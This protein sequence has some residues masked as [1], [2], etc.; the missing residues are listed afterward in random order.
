MLLHSNQTQRSQGIQYSNARL[1]G[2]YCAHS[3]H[4]YACVATT[5]P[6]C[7]GGGVGFTDFVALLLVAT[8]LLEFILLFNRIYLW[9][10][11]SIFAAVVIVVACGTIV[12]CAVAVASTQVSPTYRHP[13]GVCLSCCMS[14]C[15]AVFFICVARMWQLP[16][17]VHGRIS[18]DGS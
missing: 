14:V 7:I 6:C 1:K 3:S 12:A 16:L 2:S 10:N 9:L 18:N 15:W 13:F 17:Q 11:T 4:W 5:W 8:F